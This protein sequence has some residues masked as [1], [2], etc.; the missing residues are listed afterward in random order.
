M[1]RPDSGHRRGRP[2]GPADSRSGSRPAAAR[3][4]VVQGAAKR[5]H[6]P[7]EGGLTGRTIAL[8]LVVATLALA[9]AYPIR[10]YLTQMAEIDAMTKAQ[11]AQRQHIKA[12][13]EQ[14]ALWHDDRYLEIQV[15]KR[16]YWVQRGEIPLIPIWGDTLDTAQP[17]A[18]PKPGTW[19]ETLWSSVDAANG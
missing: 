8:L 3:R 7:T 6:P 10:E 5:T 15:R 17:P 16:I 2:G 4:P 14:E 1:P 19:Y 9:Y 12:L 13:E 11:E 18:K